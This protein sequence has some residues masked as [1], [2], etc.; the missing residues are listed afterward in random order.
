MKGKQNHY[1]LNIGKCQ[2]GSFGLLVYQWRTRE[3]SLREVVPNAIAG[4]YISAKVGSRSQLQGVCNHPTSS[5]IREQMLALQKH[6]SHIGGHITVMLL[7]EPLS[8]HR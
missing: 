5:C 6:L 1:E 3:W 2:D 8:I 4:D 7:D